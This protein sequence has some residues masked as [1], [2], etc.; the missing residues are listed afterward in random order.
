MSDEQPGKIMFEIFRDPR[1]APA[2]GVVYF[3]ELEEEERDV[4]IERAMAGE[5]ILGGFIGDGESAPQAKDAIATVLD[6]LNAG[7]S[8]DADTISELL[9]GHLVP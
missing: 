1:G 7:E 9:A 8:L 3:T 4:A 2:H 5:H 6:R